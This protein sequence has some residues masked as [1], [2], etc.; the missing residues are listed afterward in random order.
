M[1]RQGGTPTALA[2]AS[3]LDDVAEALLHEIERIDPRHWSRIPGPG[4]W[5]I[6]KDAE[7]VLEAT[8]YHRWIVELT[9]GEAVASKRPA[10]ERRELVG[11]LSAAGA[12]REIRRR[13]AENR[14]LVAGLSDVQ[15]A[16]PTKPPRA[17]S[18]SLAETIEHV[19]IGHYRAHLADI[20]T[21]LQA[22]RMADARGQ[23]PAVRS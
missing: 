16:L 1:D 18:P 14:E 21:K 2:L 12:A 7:H 5:A 8:A 17:R 13:T 9:I 10:L 20:E 23:P 15:L 22:F 11:R 19:L 6:S 3:R 4:E